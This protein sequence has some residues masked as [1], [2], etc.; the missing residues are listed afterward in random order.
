M[1]RT[2]M[3]KIQT[4]AVRFVGFLGVFLFPALL[5][6][7]ASAQNTPTIIVNCNA[8]QSLNSVLSKLNKQLPIT[9]VVQGTCAEYVF[10]NG[11]EGLTLNGAPGA[12][13]LQ[14]NTSPGNGLAVHVLSIVASRSITVDGFAIH[15]GTSALAGVG[16][17]E[18]SMNIRLRNLTL[19]GPGIFGLIA[20]EESQV[21]LARVTVRDPGFAGAGVFD[22]SDVHIESSLFESATGSGFHEALNVGSG[23]VTVQSTTIRNMQVGMDIYKNGSVDI[24][25]F[26]TYYPLSTP[27]DVVID[28]PAGTNF[29]GAKISGGSQLNVGD[30]KLRI[31]N[32]GQPWGGNSAGVSVSDSSTL[33]DLGGKL[34]VSGSQGQGIFVSNN[35]H[36]SLSGSSITGSSH[37]GLV[38]ANLST[39]AIYQGNTLTLFGGNATDLFCDSKSVIT[40]AGNLAGVPTVNCGN[41]LPG[42]TEPLP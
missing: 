27:N 33:I 29:Q 18:N 9:I 38:V 7:N 4:V 10:I 5:V 35:S 28:N 21:S 23:H 1:E 14:P 16:V 11:F 32:A 31:T 20:F 12:A 25:S 15:S 13:L 39:V 34:L 37:G 26:N 42:D 40:G 3:N 41:L 19:D 24:Q 8:G 6:S 22:V 36:A 2:F 17:G 30:T